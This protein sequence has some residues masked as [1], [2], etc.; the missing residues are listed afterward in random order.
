[1]APALATTLR[2]EDYAAFRMSISS[3][4]SD[5][6]KVRTHTIGSLSTRGSMEKADLNAWLEKVDETPVKTS[7]NLNSA[8]PICDAVEGCAT[9]ADFSGRITTMWTEEDAQLLSAMPL[10]QKE[11]KEGRKTASNARADRSVVGND[12][13]TRMSPHGVLVPTRTYSLDLP[14]DNS[15]SPSRHV[16]SD[17]SPL[18][19]TECVFRKASDRLAFAGERVAQVTEEGISMYPV[20]LGITPPRLSSARSFSNSIPSA[21]PQN[22]PTHDSRAILVEYPQDDARRVV[23]PP[24]LGMVGAPPG[25][26][27]PERSVRSSGEDV[28]SGLSNT[29]GA[30]LS[31]PDLSSTDTAKWCADSVLDTTETS[32]PPTSGLGDIASAGPIGEYDVNTHGTTPEYIQPRSASF[33]DKNHPTSLRNHV[34]TN[35]LGTCDANI[36]Q[37]V[38]HQQ[39]GFLETANQAEHIMLASTLSPVTPNLYRPLAVRSTDVADTD[40]ALP[41]DHHII[42][43]IE[44]ISWSAP[45]QKQGEPKDTTGKIVSPERTSP[46][47]VTTDVGTGKAMEWRSVEVEDSRAQ[48]AERSSPRAVTSGETIFF[49]LLPRD[50]DLSEVG[51]VASED[52]QSHRNVQSTVFAQFSKRSGSPP[53]LRTYAP[54]RAVSWVLDSRPMQSAKHS[55][56]TAKRPRSCGGQP[57]ISNWRPSMTKPSQTPFFHTTRF[58]S[59]P[60]TRPIPQTHV[61][62]TA[63]RVSDSA[64]MFPSVS[65]VVGETRSHTINSPPVSAVAVVKARGSTN[66]KSLIDLAT[67]ANIK[68][69]R[70]IIPPPP[71]SSITSNIYDRDSVVSETHRIKIG[72]TSWVHPVTRGGNVCRSITNPLPVAPE[73]PAA[74]TA[75]NISFQPV[76]QLYRQSL[77]APVAGDILRGGPSQNLLQGHKQ[78]SILLYGFPLAVNPESAARFPSTSVE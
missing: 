72:K 56:A 31:K 50:S 2:M 49:P 60:N 38:P 62:T 65:A 77:S 35:E 5:C 15:L 8:I 32:V 58:L 19:E 59:R 29:F 67:K 9:Q 71:R 76:T 73:A 10:C 74:E 39:A 3:D 22:V 75:D 52:S 44:D 26:T 54:H 23:N 47:A 1:M 14:H 69:S 36:H 30:S 34:P 78:Q 42:E 45:P 66:D 16:I 63:G 11:L 43:S 7:W 48:L 21:H 40:G 24:R 27:L 4:D 53:V 18:Q 55:T 51:S 6:K 41:S 46:L 61:V 17:V 25:S 68:H 28:S 20:P 70:I 12:E 64:S 57:F 13:V 37:D 33:V